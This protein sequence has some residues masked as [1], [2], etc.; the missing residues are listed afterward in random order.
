MGP[1]SQ[2][3]GPGIMLVMAQT[4]AQLAVV[5]LPML[6]NFT[7]SQHRPYL[8][9]YRHPSEGYIGVGVPSKELVNAG[10]SLGRTVPGGNPYA[11]RGS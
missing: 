5:G 10:M 8:A 7:L 4:L 11:F 1:C 2:P 3:Q 9:W 6:L